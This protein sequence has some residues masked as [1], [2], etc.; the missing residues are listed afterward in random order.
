MLAGCEAFMK[1]A[2]TAPG[3]EK[4]PVGGVVEAPVPGGVDSEG[5]AGAAGREVVARV[6]AEAASD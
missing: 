6:T 4:V 5:P 3:A 2:D 1:G